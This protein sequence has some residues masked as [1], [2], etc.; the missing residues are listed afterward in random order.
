MTDI[1]GVRGPDGAV[2]STIDRDTARAWIDDGTVAG[3]MIPKLRC[4]L[5]AL[6]AGVDKVHIL[7]GRLRHAMLLELFTDQGVGTE[8]V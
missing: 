1:E 6:D 8:L 3:G 4:A 2:A 5:D 7:D